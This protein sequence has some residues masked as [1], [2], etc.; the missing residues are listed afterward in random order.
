MAS[1]PA[2]ARQY[3]GVEWAG[4]GEAVAGPFDTGVGAAQELVQ[5]NGQ[6]NETIDEALVADPFDTG[7]GATRSW[8]GTGV[9]ATMA[10]QNGWMFALPRYHLASQWQ[11][12]PCL[13]LR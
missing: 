3:N 4:H 11:V 7:V 9:G 6:V 1:R 12:E 8:C 5:H 10:C 13:R 2:A